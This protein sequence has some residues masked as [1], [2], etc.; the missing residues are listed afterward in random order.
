MMQCLALPLSNTTTIIANI[1]SQTFLILT[2]NIRTKITHKQITISTVTNKRLIRIILTTIKLLVTSRILST[3]RSD[4]Q[5]KR[6]FN[7]A[8]Q[9]T[10]IA[11]ILLVS[12]GVI[13]FSSLTFPNQTSSTLTLTFSSKTCHITMMA[14]ITT[15]LV[16]KWTKVTTITLNFNNIK[17]LI[18]ELLTNHISLLR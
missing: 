15:C 14:K 16:I 2:W 11:S 5:V 17:R 7:N 8:M 3:M 1:N 10:N 6:N 13:S 9:I 18:Q 4:I 12:T